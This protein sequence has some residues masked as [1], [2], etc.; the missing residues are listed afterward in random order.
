[1]LMPE[2]C[3]H[4]I[5]VCNKLNQITERTESRSGRTLIDSG[6]AHP[7]LTK[8]NL[9]FSQHN[10]LPKRSVFFSNNYGTV[11][12]LNGIRITYI[13]SL[14]TYIIYMYYIHVNTVIKRYSYYL[15]TTWIFITFS[16]LT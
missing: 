9:L 12:C 11:L 3:E 14:Y 10:N 2:V 8:L 15:I 1:M 4:F 5:N 6:Q 16:Y 13:I 7:Y